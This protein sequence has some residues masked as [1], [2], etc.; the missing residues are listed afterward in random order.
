MPEKHSRQIILSSSPYPC[1]CPKKCS[2]QTFL[3]RRGCMKFP[4]S[5]P[6][7][8]PLELSGKS[9]GRGKGYGLIL[10][11]IVCNEHFFG[12]A[13]GHG[14]REGRNGCYSGNFSGGTTCCHPSPFKASKKLSKAFF[15]SGFKCKGIMA[16]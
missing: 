13:H 5:F 11:K 12:H 3:K 1:A 16:G 7:S 2:P 9:R 4:F 6:L 8:L 15:S 14:R 10:Y